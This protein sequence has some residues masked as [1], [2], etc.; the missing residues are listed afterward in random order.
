MHI[1]SL[2]CYLTVI[3]TVRYC[4]ADTCH[5]FQ[6]KYRPGLLKDFG[7]SYTIDYCQRGLNNVCCTMSSVLNYEKYL[8][9]YGVEI[10]RGGETGSKCQQLSRELACHYGCSSNLRVDYNTKIQSF[11]PLFSL[12]YIWHFTS[13]CRNSMWCGTWSASYDNRSSEIGCYTIRNGKIM[14]NENS[15]L[16]SKL[17]SAT[18]FARQVLDANID[19]T[20]ENKHDPPAIINSTYEVDISI[21]NGMTWLASIIVTFVVI[22]S[23]VNMFRN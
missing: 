4:S 11:Q 7:E 8:S 18:E 14:Y 3:L 9:I 21:K 16:S 6:D 19:G 23:I 13:E 2:L 5:S 12:R 15:H 20:Y 10:P 17:L 22:I 1:K